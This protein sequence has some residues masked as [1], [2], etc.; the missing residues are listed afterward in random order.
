MAGFKYNMM[1]MQA[2]IG[3]H[4]L[5]RIDVHARAARGDLR[6]LRRR[7]RR[8]AA[9]AL[10]AP[11]DAGSVHARHLYPVLLDEHG[12][13][14]L[15]RRR[16]S[17]GCASAA[18]RP[19]IHFRAVHLHPYYQERFGFRRGMFPVAEAV[20]DSTLSLPLSAAMPEERDRR[21]AC[22]EACHDVLR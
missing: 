7:A 22:I 8:T 5:A 11:V 18:S 12:G 16:C 6:A 21:R 9:A 4:Q 17:S 19:S 14:H 10:P 13:R 15:A 1:D 3:L 20:S 2:A